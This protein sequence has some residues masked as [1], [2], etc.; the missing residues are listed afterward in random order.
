MPKYLQFEKNGF[1]KNLD[2]KSIEKVHSIQMLRELYSNYF[3]ASN[4]KNENT[5]FTDNNAYVWYDGATGNIATREQ[6][7][8]II[9]K[10]DI[11]A[12]ELLL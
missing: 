2:L 11:M 4:L 7:R 1:L 5:T 6:I 12:W 9:F 8:V 3:C 10:L